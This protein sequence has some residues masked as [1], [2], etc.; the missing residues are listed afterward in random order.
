MNRKGRLTTLP[1]LL[2]GILVVSGCNRG[3]G[4]ALSPEEQKVVYPV[5]AVVVVEAPLVQYIKLNGGVYP[6]N[7][8]SLYPDVAGK[9]ASIRTAAGRRISRGNVVLTVDPSRPGANFARNP[10]TSTITGTVIDIPF[11]VGDTVSPQTPVAT[12][13][14]LDRL[15]ARLNVAERYSGSLAVGKSGELSFIAYPDTI[16]PATITEVS[17]VLD[18]ATRSVEVSVAPD[19]NDPRIKAGMFAEVKLILGEK[20]TLA[21]PSTALLVRGGRTLLFVVVEEEGESVAKEREVTTGIV[22]EGMTEI[23]TGIDPEDRVIVSGQTLV[24]DGAFV[25]E[26]EG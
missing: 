13:G 18:A 10:V 2:S 26:S 25:T 15:E 24:S 14:N 20:M 12:V 6:E 21:V 5:R 22:S 23:L 7:S 19:R 3:R 8:V 11:K 1:L 9:V 17:P 16:F 4:E